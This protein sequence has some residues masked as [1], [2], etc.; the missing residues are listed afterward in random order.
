M[1]KKYSI[2]LDS[3]TQEITRNLKNLDE[4]ELL[5][6]LTAE[7]N[8]FEFIILQRMNINIINKPKTDYNPNNNSTIQQL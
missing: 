5:G 8:Y 2:I 6:I 3:D 4:L 7:K 1:I